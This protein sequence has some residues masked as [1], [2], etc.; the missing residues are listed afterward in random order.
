MDTRVA[1]LATILVLNTDLLLNCLDLFQEQARDRL[2]G[3]GNGVIFLAARAATSGRR[4]SC[5]VG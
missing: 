2:D 5:G 4:R 3:G 1:P